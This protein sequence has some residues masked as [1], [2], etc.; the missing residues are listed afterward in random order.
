MANFSLLLKCFKS[1]YFLCFSFEFFFH[2]KFSHEMKGLPE[3]IFF[4]VKITDML[5]RYFKT[6]FELL[7][8]RDLTLNFAVAV[9]QWPGRLITALCSSGVIH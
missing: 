8:A 1:F 9:M 6:K 4:R 2:L 3:T 7:S 5:T